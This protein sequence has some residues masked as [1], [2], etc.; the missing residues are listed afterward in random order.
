MDTRLP[1]S[2]EDRLA[3]Q[4]LRPMSAAVIAAIPQES[5]VRRV[6]SA[7]PLLEPDDMGFTGLILITLSEREGV[8][9]YACVQKLD[10]KGLFLNVRGLTN[11]LVQSLL[12]NDAVPGGIDVD[13]MI[14][15]GWGAI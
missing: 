4:V 12:A 2:G 9:L 15:T 6:V 10:R 8:G 5:T 11:Q 3:P 13:S 1:A 7:A 14:Q